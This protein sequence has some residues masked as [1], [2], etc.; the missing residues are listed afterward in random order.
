MSHSIPLYAFTLY[1]I[2]LVSVVLEIS[3]ILYSVYSDQDDCVN[4]KA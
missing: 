4:I 3:F 2:A 1:Y